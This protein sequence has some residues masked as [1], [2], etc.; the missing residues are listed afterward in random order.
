MKRLET[1]LNEAQRKLDEA[2]DKRVTWAREGE[3][4]EELEAKK[5][6]LVE[7]QKEKSNCLRALANFEARLHSELLNLGA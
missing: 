4:I 2:N 6:K 3:A 5:R 7:L 1:E